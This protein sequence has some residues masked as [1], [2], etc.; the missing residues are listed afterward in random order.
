MNLDTFIQTVIAGGRNA[1]RW[2]GLERIYFQS[3]K[4]RKAEKIEDGNLKGPIE[5]SF[6]T[7]SLA[8]HQL[9]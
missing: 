7:H 1:S 8:K 3:L 2:L 6:L 9:H 5:Y 4:G